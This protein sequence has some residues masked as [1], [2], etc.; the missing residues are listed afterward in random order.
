M[1]SE[2]L[3]FSSPDSVAEAEASYL[4]DESGFAEAE[5]TALVKKIERLPDPDMIR[6][7]EDALAHAREG[8]TVGIL[9]IEKH[10]SSSSWSCAGIP[11]RFE[12]TGYL[13]HLA[14]KMQTDD[15]PL[16]LRSAT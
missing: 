10:P 16:P 6:V 14:Y 12:I 8:R 15:A 1:S 3:P 7:L 2:G 13:F 4:A 5:M 11:D 9:L